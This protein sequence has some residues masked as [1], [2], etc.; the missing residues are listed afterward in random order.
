VNGIGER[1]SMR[2]A[3]LVC[4]V[5]AVVTTGGIADEA[6]V[7]TGVAPSLATLLALRAAGHKPGDALPEGTVIEVVDVGASAF[8]V[9]RPTDPKA[10]WKD[11]LA[12]HYKGAV[13]V[14][15][16]L[17]LAILSNTTKVTTAVKP[18]D[19]VGDVGELRLPKVAG[20]GEPAVF[21][22]DLAGLLVRAFDDRVGSAGFNE[23]ELR[24]RV[25]HDMVL[26]LTTLGKAEEHT[27]ARNP[28]KQLTFDFRLLCVLRTVNDDL[29]KLM[30][31]SGKQRDWE[32]AWKIHDDILVIQQQM[33]GAI[34]DSHIVVKDALK[35]RLESYLSRFR[36]ELEQELRHRRR[37]LAAALSREDVE[38]ARG[39]IQG[40]LYQMKPAIGGIIPLQTER[41]LYADLCRIHRRYVAPMTRERSLAFTNHFSRMA[42]LL[43]PPSNRDNYK[44][45]FKISDVEFQFLKQ[46]GTIVLHTDCSGFIGRI[47]RELARTAGFDMKN[48]IVGDSGII[49]SIYMIEPKVS[50]RVELAEGKTPWTN[51]QQGDF[52]YFERKI[53]GERQRHVIFFD[54]V[55]T[56]KDGTSEISLWEASPGGVK[57]RTKPFDWVDKWLS[58]SYGAPRNGVYRL[59]E[60]DRIDTILD[61]RGFIL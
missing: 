20:M 43:A 17:P 7:D 56:K 27:S 29:F 50:K 55:V 57:H 25:L 8:D 38:Q 21:L 6:V 54:R 39:Q 37:M 60:M 9:V 24:Y 42:A 46:S 31:A 23:L 58:S 40:I 18:T 10:T 15:Q 49:G 4:C 16:A 47:Y 12:G 51:M 13:S 14:R 11:L 32:L 41:S 59:K 36:G 34:D 33:A 5:A 35:G 1:L 22:S 48:F 45:G 61:R 30:Q 2:R 3:V 26:P 53:R 44:L 19:A 28:I 52:F